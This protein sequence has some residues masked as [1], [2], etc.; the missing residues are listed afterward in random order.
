MGPAAPPTALPYHHDAAAAWTA[1]PGAAPARLGGGQLEVGA[2]Q[3]ASCF[4]STVHL[5]MKRSTTPGSLLRP[6]RPARPPCS[7]EEDRVLEN[8]LA[9][10]WEHTDRWVAGSGPSRADG[11]PGGRLPPRPPPLK[12]LVFEPAASQAGEVCLA[13]VPQGPG[14]SEAAVPAAGGATSWLPGL[15]GAGQRLLCMPLA[16]PPAGSDAVRKQGIVPHCSAAASS[17]Q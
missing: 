17:L 16:S 10:F 8:A 2:L 14:G 3:A 9:Q 4:Q 1:A 7:V 11:E 12:R 15:L 6:Q 13:A 5:T